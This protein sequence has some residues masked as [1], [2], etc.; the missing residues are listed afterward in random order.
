MKEK[1]PKKV[2]KYI[3][4]GM[5]ETLENARFVELDHPDQEYSPLNGRGLLQ[6]RIIEDTKIKEKSISLSIIAI[7]I[8]LISLSKS[9]GWIDA[10]LQSLSP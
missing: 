4:R 5:E 10:I 6:L 7:I 2:K 1:N 8:S 3:S 9:M